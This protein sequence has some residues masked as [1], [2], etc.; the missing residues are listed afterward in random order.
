MT[1]VF[2][3]TV[4]VHPRDVARFLEVSEPTIEKMKRE[5]ELMY[6]EMYQVHDS[7]GTITWIEKWY[8]KSQA[9]ALPDATLQYLNITLGLNPW[10]GY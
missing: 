9:H 6:F 7:P 8:A 4:H 1:T 2:Q 3:V 10:I 5:S